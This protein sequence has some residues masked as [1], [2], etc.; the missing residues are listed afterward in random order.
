L[1][2]RNRP[3][4]VEILRRCVEDRPRLHRTAHRDHRDRA[5][6]DGVEGL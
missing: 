5:E 4:A 2:I 6:R 3:H 1:E